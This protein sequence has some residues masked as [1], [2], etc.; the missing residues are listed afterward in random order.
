[1]AAVQDVEHPIGKHQR[2]THFFDTR[3]HIRRLADLDFKGW[4]RMHGASVT[5]RR[6]MRNRQPRPEPA[7]AKAT[8]TSFDA[9]Y[10]VLTVKETG[11][12]KQ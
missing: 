7:A 11:R 5:R 2:A 1:M 4:N 12:I 9:L 3:G 10:K 8:P 6:S